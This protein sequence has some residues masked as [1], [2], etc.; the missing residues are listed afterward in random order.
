[1]D[2]DDKKLLDF[3][4]V[5]VGLLLYG[6]FYALPFDRIERKQSEI[7]QKLNEAAK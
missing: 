4:W 7:M 2:D 5:I 6:Y 1:M 3:V